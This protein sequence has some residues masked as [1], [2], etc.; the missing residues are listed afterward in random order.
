M[1]HIKRLVVLNPE[2]QW[3][4]FPKSLLKKSKGLFPMTELGVQL[5]EMIRRHIVGSRPLLRI[6]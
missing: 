2:K 3:R 5:G 6:V 4:M 1:E